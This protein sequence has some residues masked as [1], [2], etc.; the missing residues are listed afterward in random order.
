[1]AGDKYRIKR[2]TVAMFMDGDHHVAHLVL[3]GSVI[4]KHS[5]EI[6]WSRS[7]GPKSLS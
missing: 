3:E 7:S 6:C 1:M 2:T 4:H 5:T